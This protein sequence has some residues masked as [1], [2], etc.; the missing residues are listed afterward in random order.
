MIMS[1]YFVVAPG[2]DRICV[3]AKPP[4]T[5]A[6]MPG[7]RVFR[8]DVTLPDCVVVDG[9]VQSAAAV[10]VTETLRLT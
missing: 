5:L 3:Q 6:K 7:V 1:V 8:A 2:M 4:T 9:V 10:D